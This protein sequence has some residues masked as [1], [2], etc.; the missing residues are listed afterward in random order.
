MGRTKLHFWVRYL[1][2]LVVLVVVPLILRSDYWMS[3]VILSGVYI[4]LA[5]G[6]NLMVGVSGQFVVCVAAF[7]GIGAYCSSLLVLRLGLPFWL[8]MPIGGI[9]AAAVGGGIGF[10]CNRFRGHYVA[11]VT[12]SFGVITYEIMLHW[13][14]L[15]KGPMGLIKIP[16]PE[17]LPLGL[18]TLDFKSKV[19]FYIFI[20]GLVFL[21]IASMNR[22]INS[23]PGRALLAIRE[24]GVAAEVLGIDI[25]KYKI[26]AFI[27]GAW[28]AGIVGSFYAH[29]AGIIVPGTFSFLISV[30]I[31]VIVI[32][33]GLGSIYGVLVSAIILTFLPEFLRSVE[34]LRWIIYGI[35]LMVMI[36]FMPSGI[37][38]VGRILRF[39]YLNKSAIKESLE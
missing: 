35:I 39:R 6:L 27:F 14:S 29:F 4:I 12:L 17:R 7:Y 2:I 31:L 16:V 30:E 10:V 24:D 8:S 33:G 21:C 22:L 25:D 20:I 13:L 18:F 36:I 5:Q 23:R 28:W 34:F 32:V 1:L 15:T 37:A 38:G 19:D 11:L 9:L 26:K 3:I